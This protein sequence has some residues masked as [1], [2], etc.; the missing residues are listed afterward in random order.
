MLRLAVHAQQYSALDASAC[1]QVLIVNVNFRKLL[2]GT[3]ALKA[4]HERAI[5]V[6]FASDPTYLHRATSRR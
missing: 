6:Q 1:P 3:T 5:G 2:R 4:T